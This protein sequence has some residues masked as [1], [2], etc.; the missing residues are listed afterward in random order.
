MVSAVPSMKVKII[1]DRQDTYTCL[2]SSAVGLVTDD[3]DGD[4]AAIWRPA[5]KLFKAGGA[6]A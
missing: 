1:G 6:V 4:E 3:A 2:Y 5:G